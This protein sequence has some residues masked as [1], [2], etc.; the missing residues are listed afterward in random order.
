[1]TA[2][3]LIEEVNAA[4]G[5]V[6]VA[7]RGRIR[8]TN[9]PT[10][11]AG[12]LKRLKPEI[13]SYLCEGNSVQAED[14]AREPNCYT[15]DT[16]DWNDP[17]LKNISPLRINDNDCGPVTDPE[18]SKPRI[19]PFTGLPY[20]PRYGTRRMGKASAEWLEQLST[21]NRHEEVK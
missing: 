13:V 2:R 17:F 11:L 15:L 10:R 19:S 12:D 8:V 7:P 1:M 20:P 14:G 18:P 3:E 4:G 21:A 5:T 9:A 6:E 16:I